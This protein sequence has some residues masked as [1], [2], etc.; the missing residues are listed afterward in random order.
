[1]RE[2]VIVR[3]APDEYDAFR[4]MLG[5][6]LPIA[7]DTWLENS[8]SFAAQRRAQGYRIEEVAVSLADF[9]RYRLTETIG[10]SYDLLHACAV[11]KARRASCGA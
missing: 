2:A 7:Y 8:Q 4:S 3:L 10:P 1:M 6:A 11:A 9:E 5:R